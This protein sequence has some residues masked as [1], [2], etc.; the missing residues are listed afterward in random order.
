[1]EIVYADMVTA[2]AK[3]GQDI[4][5]SL[6]PEGCHLWHMASC[7]PGEAGELFDAIKKFVIYN[8]PLDLE[9]AIEELGDLE[10]YM[11]GLR[12]GL[13]ITREQTLDANVAKLGTRY[14]GLRYSDKAAQERADKRNY[15]GA[16][17]GRIVAVQEP[18]AQTTA[19]M[20]GA[21]AFQLVKH[22]IVTGADPELIALR[23]GAD[24][25]FEPGTI[26]YNDFRAGFLAAGQFY[27]EHGD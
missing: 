24:N 26:G 22:R 2:L 21:G 18:P 16:G 13:G 25:P 5:D 12:Q 8:K 20:Q 7:I 10:F 1:M 15:I 17:V 19:A 23:E 6:T 11:E 27:I 9:N 14:A 4:L 3:P